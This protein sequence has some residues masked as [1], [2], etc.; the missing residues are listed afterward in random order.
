VKNHACYEKLRA[1]G[2]IAAWF[3]SGPL[4]KMVRQLTPSGTLN[5]L[6]LRVLLKS[7]MVFVRAVLAR[8]KGSMVTMLKQAPRYSILGIGLAMWSIPP[9]ERV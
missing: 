5:E 6:S 3:L 2:A 7:N 1:Y 8:L 9:D 4:F